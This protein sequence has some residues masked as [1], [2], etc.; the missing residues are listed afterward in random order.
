[1]AFRPVGVRD[2]VMHRRYWALCSD[3]PRK[4]SRIEIDRVDGK[5]VYMPIRS[6]EDVHTA[7]KLCTGLF[8]RLP[9]EGTDFAIRVPRS[10]DFERMTPEEWLP[11]WQAVLDVCLETIAPDIEAPEARADLLRYV[12][13][14]TQQAEA[15]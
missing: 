9:I 13:R 15:A 10:T 12:E 11:Y 7:F 5:P 1:K 6:R 4:V 8:D 2:P 3:L 14:W